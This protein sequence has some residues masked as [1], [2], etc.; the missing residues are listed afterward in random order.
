M[1]ERFDSIMAGLQ[2]ALAYEK[3]DKTRARSRVREFG[4]TI[5]PV[6]H[7]D[8]EA[9]RGIRME[10]NLS[11]KSFAEALGVSAKTVEAWEAGTNEPAGSSSR[12]IELLVKDHQLLERFD[13]ITRA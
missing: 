2:D 10:L 5:K 8:K 1:G 7:F 11:Q 6:E 13:V 4:V 9:I 12:M 3:G